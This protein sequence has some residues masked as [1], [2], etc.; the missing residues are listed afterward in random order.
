[1]F[2]DLIP[3]ADGRVNIHLQKRFLNMLPPDTHHFAE[4]PGNAIAAIHT[5]FSCILIYEIYLLGAVPQ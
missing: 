5:S 4:L 2:T 1:M 3:H